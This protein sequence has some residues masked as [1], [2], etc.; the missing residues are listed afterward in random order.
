MRL[1][2]TQVSVVFQCSLQ[3][4]IYMCV[5]LYRLQDSFSLYTEKCWVVKTTGQFIKK[6]I[7]LT[8]RIKI[9][10]QIFELFLSIL[11]IMINWTETN[12][13]MPIRKPAFDSQA[14]T[15]PYFLLKFVS[16]PY[17]GTS[18]TVTSSKTF[19]NTCYPCHSSFL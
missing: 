3:S 11:S 17:L 14:V 7:H 18:L 5:A 6:L 2:E 8:G 4:T 12:N 19:P 15:Y 13:H 10:T 16:C 1:P 9:R